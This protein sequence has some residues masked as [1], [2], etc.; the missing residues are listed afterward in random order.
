M[1]LAPIIFAALAISA[2]AAMPLDPD[3]SLTSLLDTD[4]KAKKENALQTR[5]KTTTTCAHCAGLKRA[6]GLEG[7]DSECH[8]N[9][10]SETALEGS[11]DIT[12]D[13][14]SCAN[15]YAFTS[16]WGYFP[17]AWGENPNTLVPKCKADTTAN[18]CQDSEGTFTST[19]ILAT[20][21]ILKAPMQIKDDYILVP[22]GNGNDRTGGLGG[23][24][25]FTVRAATDTFVEFESQFHAPSAAD[26]A[27]WIWIDDASPATACDRADDCTSLKFEWMLPRGTGWMANGWPWH[28]IDS[29]NGRSVLRFPLSAGDHTLHVGQ[30]DDGA[31]LHA[32]RISSGDALFI[33]AP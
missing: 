20:G 16:D 19:E 17:C 3:E 31:R 24:A 14:M 2:F 25:A 18:C 6:S 12:A 10:A 30:Y 4:L 7:S 21:G 1:N 15:Y 11:Y 9:P 33:S 26:G 5:A 29:G 22:N 28:A 13:Q 27:F 8:D 32:L 23:E